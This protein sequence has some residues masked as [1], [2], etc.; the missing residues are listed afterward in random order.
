M[1]YAVVVTA[2]PGSREGWKSRF[3]RR[4]CWKFSGKALFAEQIDGRSGLATLDPAT[5][6]IE[7]LWTGSE[8]NSTG[9]WSFGVS[10]GRDGKACALVLESYTQPPEVWA[11]PIGAWKPVT[12]ANRDARVSWGKAESIH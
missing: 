10:L 6:K 3:R 11:G 9:G 8:S 2:R 5:G 1:S 4:A 12:H 7:A